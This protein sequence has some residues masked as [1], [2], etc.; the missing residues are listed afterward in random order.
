MT[1]EEVIL[2]HKRVSL[3]A[4]KLVCSKHAGDE[5]L[6]NMFK[7]YM[8]LLTKFL[9]NKIQKDPEFFKSTNYRAIQNPKTLQSK[10]YSD[11]ISD[12]EVLELDKKLRS[13]YLNGSNENIGS[14]YWNRDPFGPLSP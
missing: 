3:E 1:T 9:V 2:V 11:F 7:R 14:V 6:I 4:I 10:V 12:K 13:L 5:Q 8:V